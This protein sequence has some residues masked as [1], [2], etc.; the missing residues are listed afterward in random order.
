MLLEP[1]L[2]SVY[3]GLVHKQPLAEL[4]DEPAQAIL[5][6]RST[7]SVEHQR[8]TDGPYRSRR[9][10]PMERQLA[11]AGKEAGQREDQLGWD[12]REQVLDDERADYPGIPH[13]LDHPDY[14]LGESAE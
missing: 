3:V 5:A 14:P 8:A 9:P 7:E 4:P 2:S 1:A 12:R 13:G 11:P 10:R 6:E